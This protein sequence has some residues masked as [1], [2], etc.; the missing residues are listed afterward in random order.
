M[1][2]CSNIMDRSENLSYL[3][4][5]SFSSIRIS[6]YFNKHHIK[7]SSFQSKKINRNIN[8]DDLIIN[9]IKDDII[10]CHNNLNHN[11]HI[12]NM[13]ILGNCLL[14]NE[15][16]KDQFLNRYERENKEDQ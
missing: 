14:K 2:D 4:K 1:G 6:N 8:K 10:I 11:L 5:N 13:D 7:K 9:E 16:K 3:S 12:C 15:S